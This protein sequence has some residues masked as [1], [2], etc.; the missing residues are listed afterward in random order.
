MN[1]LSASSPDTEIKKARRLVTA[2]RA[3][4]SL[5]DERLE[6]SRAEL[7]EAKD[8]A[9]T[10]ADSIAIAQAFSGSIQTGVIGKFEDLLTRAIRQI[11][12]REYEVRIELAAKGNSMWADFRILLPNGRLVDLAGGEGGGFKDIVAVMSRILYL[13]LDPTAPARIM[14][15]D[16]NLKALDQWRSPAA[17]PIITKIARDLGIQVIWISHSP[18]VTDG[19]MLGIDKTYRF[20]LENDATV[21]ELVPWIGHAAGQEAQ[22]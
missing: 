14:F 21:A 12:G 18:V 19:Q 13:V 7:A 6:R 11:Y 2:R 22:S 1:H 4:K 15:L 9:Q 20:R 5:L 16:E 17:F 3:E 10:A 8:Q